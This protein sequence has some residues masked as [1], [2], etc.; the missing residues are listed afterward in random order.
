MHALGPSRRVGL[1]KTRRLIGISASR[2]PNDPSGGVS[3]RGL[4]SRAGRWSAQHRKKAIWGWLAFVL[5]AFAIGSAL[6]TTTQDT[7]HDGVAESGRAE[8]PP[9][10]ALPKHQVEQ[11]LVQSSAATATDPSFKAAVADV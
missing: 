8:R 11:V 9:A 3:P 1:P 7:A 4:A 2:P 5:L 6:G 10:N